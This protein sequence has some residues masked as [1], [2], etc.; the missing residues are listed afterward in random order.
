MAGMGHDT[1]APA[2][3]VGSGFL[4]EEPLLGLQPCG[5]GFRV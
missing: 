2:L 1:H 3:L 4:V 5:F